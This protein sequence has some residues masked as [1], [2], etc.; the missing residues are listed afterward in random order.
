MKRIHAVILDDHITPYRLPLFERLA[1]NDLRVTVL[2]CSRRLPDREWDL[3]ETLGFEAEVLPS[4]VLHFP[5]RFFRAGKRTVIVNF[6]LFWRLLRLRPDVVVGYAFSMPAW[7]AFLYAWLFRKPYVSWSTDTL[8]TESSMDVLQQSSRRIIIGG[9]ALCITPS[10]QGAAKFRQFGV[11]PDRIRIAAQTVPPEFGAK[12]D[13]ARKTADTYRHQHGLV[14]RVIL[15]TGFLTQ[16]KGMDDLIE[17]FIQVAQCRSDAHLLLVGSGNFASDI[18]Q[19]VSQAGFASRLHIAG[20]VQP[21][22]LPGIYAGADVFVFPTRGDTFGVVVAEAIACGLPVICSPYA[23]TAGMLVEDGRNGYIVDPANH[24]QMAQALLKILESDA[25]AA[26]MSQASREI[27]QHW[28]ID[29]AASNYRL[30]LQDA[31]KL[32][33]R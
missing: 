19:R 17:V 8:H 29:D 11:P 27:A 26:R 2:Y 13:L 18:T 31:H 22:S 5:W 33:S 25:G 23:G 14:G 16:S 6:N 30:A 9:S 3:P 4:W 1:A 28:N 21:P 12:A 20:F 32:K 10:L 15:Y 7:T 24:D